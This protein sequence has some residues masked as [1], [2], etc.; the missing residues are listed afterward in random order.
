MTTKAFYLEL[1]DRLSR[2][3]EV[4]IAISLDKRQL[5]EHYFEKNIPNGVKVFAERLHGK[6]K[7]VLC[8]GGHV[9]LALSKLLSLLDYT[10]IVVDDRDEF[11]N[12]MR[13]PFA[14]KLYCLDFEKGL[15]SFEDGTYYVIMTRGH[16]SDYTCL[17]QI[18]RRNYAYVGM[19][20]SQLKVALAKECLKEEGFSDEVISSVHAPIGLP[21]GGSTPMEIAVSIAAELVQERSKAETTIFDPAVAQ[22]IREAVHGSFLATVAESFGSVPRGRGSRMLIQPTG[23][24]IGSVGGGAIEHKVIERALSLKEEMVCL[25]R[26]ELSNQDAAGLGMVCGGQVL[27]LLERLI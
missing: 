21:I 22:G 2:K 19:I 26:Y 8:G 24:T 16:Q 3:A 15:P 27:I 4:R 18:L 7:T 13:F 20:G 25:E 1:I 11:V 12:P 23:Q 17:S 10:V 6:K 14:D 5:G 9:S